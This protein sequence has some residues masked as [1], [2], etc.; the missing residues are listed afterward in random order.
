MKAVSH[1]SPYGW[2]GRIGLIVPSTNT[3]N[4]PEF[5]RLVPR[6]V[7]V[8]SAR[9]HGDAVFGTG[10][11]EIAEIPVERGLGAPPKKRI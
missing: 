9:P 7:A 2:R 8:H 6:G 1:Y 10:A 4:E 11:G 3:I 5:A